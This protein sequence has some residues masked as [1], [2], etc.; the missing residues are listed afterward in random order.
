MQVS[1]IQLFDMIIP[2][3]LAQMFATP[4]IRWWSRTNEIHDTADGAKL[5]VSWIPMMWRAVTAR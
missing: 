2:F 4:N 1:I 5:R 3:C